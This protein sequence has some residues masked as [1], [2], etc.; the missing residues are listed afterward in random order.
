ML[1]EREGFGVRSKQSHRHDYVLVFRPLINRWAHE[2][3]ALLILKLEYHLFGTNYPEKV[4]QVLRVETNAQALTGI[5]QR[6]L[7]LP[8]SHISALRSDAY[9]AAGQFDLDA[10]TSLVSHQRRSPDFLRAALMA[11]E[12]SHGAA[13]RIACVIRANF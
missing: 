7:L 2:R 8:L 9:L 1:R 13:R 4:E 3:G 5:V 10:V 12:R 6:N 11:D